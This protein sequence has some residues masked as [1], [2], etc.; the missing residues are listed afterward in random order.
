MQT[1]VKVVYINRRDLNSDVVE[2]PVHRRREC[3]AFD[4]HAE[5]VYL[6][7]EESGDGNPAEAE[8][9]EVEGDADGDYKTGD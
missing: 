5:G 6:C 1:P 2:E 4:A 3:G 7:G 8:D 9:E